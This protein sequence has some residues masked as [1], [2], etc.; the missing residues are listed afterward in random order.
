M[1]CT[2]IALNDDREDI[3]VQLASRCCCVWLLAHVFHCPPLSFSFLISTRFNS[4]PILFV[5]S[6]LF[7]ISSALFRC[8][9]RYVKYGQIGASMTNTFSKVWIDKLRTLEDAVPPQDVSVVLGTIASEYVMTAS[10]QSSQWQ[11]CNM[12][13][14]VCPRACDSLRSLQAE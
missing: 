9:L 8:F 7:P 3:T 6:S 13:A 10:H 1:V 4:L 14:R 2:G 5:S 11:P 12:R